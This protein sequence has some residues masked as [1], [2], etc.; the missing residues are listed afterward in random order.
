[1][2]TEENLRRHGH[3]GGGPKFWQFHGGLGYRLLLK[4][5]LDKSVHASILYVRSGV[6]L[7]MWS[8]TAFYL[9]YTSV[10]MW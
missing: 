2:K 1:M 8:R 3:N 7:K 10:G 5:V 4:A 9:F 6:C